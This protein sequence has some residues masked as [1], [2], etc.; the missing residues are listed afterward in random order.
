M[1]Y[2]L[3]REVKRYAPQTLTH[4][5]KLTAMVLADDANDT[6][7][8]TWNSAFDPEIMSA[9]MVKNDREM[10]KV[11]ARL[12]EEKVIEHAGGGHNGR[13]AKFR[14]LH[15]APAT[16]GG[17]ERTAYEDPNRDG[18]TQKEPP[19]EGVGGPFRASSRSKKNLPTPFSPQD[20]SSPPA[21]PAHEAPEPPAATDTEREKIS[22]ND[23][24]AVL[25]AYATALGRPVSPTA[26]AKLT[27]QAADYLAAGFPA[28]WLQERAT[29][30]AA[31][32]WTDLA[33]HCDRST[34]PTIR[35]T[36]ET[37]AD[38]CGH[39][40]DP[41]YR[42]RKDPARDNELVQ[43]DDCHPAA[44]ARRRRTETGAAA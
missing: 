19:T 42:M 25:A 39:C 14:F 37:K 26:A 29:E 12:Q 11:L 21:A 16:V 2:E 33:Q 15:M 41:S 3:Y 9:C 7:R 17:P 20:L 5:E 27:A 30:L 10:R 35:K 4:R 23:T 36:T 13:V 22:S 40:D 31:R 34:A 38:W 32:G 1:G 44:V 18:V 8:S 6:S 24:D 43:C 28:W